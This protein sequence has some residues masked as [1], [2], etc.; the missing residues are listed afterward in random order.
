[1]TKEQLTEHHLNYGER[2]GNFFIKDDN[3]NVSKIF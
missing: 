2:V 3:T 1:M